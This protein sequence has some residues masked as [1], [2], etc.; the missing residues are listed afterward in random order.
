MDRPEPGGQQLE[1]GERL[2][3]QLGAKARAGL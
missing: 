3:Q 2:L 1:S